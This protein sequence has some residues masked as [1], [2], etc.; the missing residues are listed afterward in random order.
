MRRQSCRHSREIAVLVCMAA[1]VGYCDCL[2]PLPRVTANVIPAQRG[3]SVGLCQSFHIWNESKENE[4]A[5]RQGNASPWRACLCFVAAAVVKLVCAK[6]T[7]Q[8]ARLKI[9]K[10]V[11]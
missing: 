6:H 2:N 7:A 10:L 5:I 1:Q 4:L 3:R 9:A 8:V 11:L